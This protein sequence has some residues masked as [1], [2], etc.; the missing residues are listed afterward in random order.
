LLV[1]KYSIDLS[2]VGR[3][4]HRPQIGAPV[5]DDREHQRKARRGIKRAGRG[6]A[7]LVN[8]AAGGDPRSVRPSQEAIG[9]GRYDLGCGR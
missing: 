1:S 3:R 7:D 5:Q 4:L 8:Q 9:T 6:K 2:R